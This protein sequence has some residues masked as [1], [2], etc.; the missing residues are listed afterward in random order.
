MTDSKYSTI[1]QSAMIDPKAVVN[2]PVNFAKHVE[3]H[4]FTNIGKFTFVNQFSVVYGRTTMG[5]YCTIARNCEIG[6]ANHPIDW[7]ATQGNFRPYFPKHPDLGSSEHFP[8]IAHPPTK[9][10]NDVWLGCGVVVKSGVTIGDGAIVAA[11]AVVVG[12]IEPYAI[13]GGIPAKFIRNRFEQDIIESLIRL[14]WWDLDTAFVAKLPRN[15][16]SA[17]IAMIEEYKKKPV[18]PSTPEPAIP[19]PVAGSDAIAKT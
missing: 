5:K 9:I 10:G 19:A 15:D 4:P 11:G 7:L 8:T 1:A 2:H 16:I 12:D 3:I 18:E 14:K 6:V 13:Y 17:S